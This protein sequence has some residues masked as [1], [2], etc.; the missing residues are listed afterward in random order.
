REQVARALGCARRA[1]EARQPGSDAPGSLADALGVVMPLAETAH[2]GP[3]TLAAAFLYHPIAIGALGADALLACLGPEF[4]GEVVALIE[5]RRAVEGLPHS[6][7][8]HSA[9]GSQ[10]TT[11]ADGEQQ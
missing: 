2:A 10:H 8:T 7:K 4:G 11:E 9:D 6:A 5:A 3:V 1:Y